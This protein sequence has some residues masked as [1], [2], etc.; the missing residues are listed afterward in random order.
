MPWVAPPEVPQAVAHRRTSARGRGGGGGR[1]SEMET[2][3][4]LSENSGF[5]PQI[6]PLVLEL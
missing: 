1:S 3:M 2:D 5:S 6:I 4:D